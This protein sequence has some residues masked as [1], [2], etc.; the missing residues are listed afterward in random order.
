MVVEGFELTTAFSY[1]AVVAHRIETKTYL[2]IMYLS[3]A[4]CL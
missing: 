3:L 4:S 2:V 1:F